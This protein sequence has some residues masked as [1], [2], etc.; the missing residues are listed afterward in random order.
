MRFCCGGTY[1]NT[2]SKLIGTLALAVIALIVCTAVVAGYKALYFDAQ[3]QPTQIQA[4]RF[5]EHSIAFK[6]GE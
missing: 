2:L 3:P 5:A 6:P 4:Q 1:A